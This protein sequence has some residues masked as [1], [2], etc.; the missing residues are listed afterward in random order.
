MRDDFVGEAAQV[1]LMQM[2]FTAYLEDC[3]IIKENGFRNTSKLC[4]SLAEILEAY[5]RSCSRQSCRVHGET[6]CALSARLAQIR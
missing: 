4:S 5:I 1:L 2:M 6:F 3:K